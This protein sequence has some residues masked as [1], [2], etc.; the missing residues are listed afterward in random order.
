MGMQRYWAYTRPQVQRPV[1]QKQLGPKIAPLQYQVCSISTVARLHG[2]GPDTHFARAG[3][4]HGVRQVRPPH[5]GVGSLLLKHLV[6]AV[7]AGS[8]STTA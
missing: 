1:K 3:H 8:P 4:V 5:A 2:S 6:R 7:S